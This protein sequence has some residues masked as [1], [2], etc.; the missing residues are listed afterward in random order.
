MIKIEKFIEKFAEAVEIDSFENLNADT[1]FRQLD[2]WSSLASLSV[3][4]MIDEE[5]D[6]TVN[7]TMLRD[8][9]TIGDLAKL[10]EQ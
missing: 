5:Y 7:G 3:I 6:R 4:A 10:T 1:E 8:C 9:K 2:E